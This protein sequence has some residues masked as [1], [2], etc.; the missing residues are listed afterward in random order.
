MSLHADVFI[1][2]SETGWLKSTYF[3]VLDKAEQDA[4]DVLGVTEAVAEEFKKNYPQIKNLYIKSD[5]AGYYHNAS[6]IE[7][8][9]IVFERHD[10]S[11]RRLQ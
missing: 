7:G 8:V 4:L 10:I 6:M 2:K 11:V 1:M 9:K 5:N 3:T